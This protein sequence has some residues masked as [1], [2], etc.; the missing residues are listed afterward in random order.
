MQHLVRCCVCHE[1]R[2]AG[3]WDPRSSPISPWESWDY[4]CERPHQASWVPGNLNTVSS[5][6]WASDLSIEPFLQLQVSFLST[7]LPS[8]FTYKKKIGGRLLSIQYYFCLNMQPY[9]LIQSSN[10]CLLR[11]H[12]AVYSGSEKQRWSWCWLHS[13][14]FFIHWRPV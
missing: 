9:S 14:N 8:T 7:R 11:T 6:L 2:Q 4:R 3:P 10:R 12:Y 1:S 5:T 13:C